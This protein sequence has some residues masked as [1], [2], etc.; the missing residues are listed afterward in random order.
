MSRYLI[1]P[2]AEKDLDDI[3]HYIAQDNREAAMLFY[4][5]AEET[6]T[7]L[8]QNPLI[9]NSYPSLKAE[10]G[11]VQFFPIKK[12][13]NYLIFY[14]PESETINVIRILH[15]ARKIDQLIQ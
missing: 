2:Q 10:L 11:N 8:A 7:T 3:A 12:F 4:E 9:G 15:G 6:L 13:S 14:I 5:R 1:T